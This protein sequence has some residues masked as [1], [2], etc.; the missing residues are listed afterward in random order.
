MDD[1]IQGG[2]G[3]CVN[4]ISIFRTREMGG[5][6]DE[7]GGAESIVHFGLFNSLTQFF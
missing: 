5:E 2:M 4:G 1:D 7:R 6:C 3:E